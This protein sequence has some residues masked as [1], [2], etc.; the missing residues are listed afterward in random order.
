MSGHFYGL[1]DFDL[2]IG[3]HNNYHPSLGLFLTKYSFNTVGINERDIVSGFSLYPNPSSNCVNI[4]FENEEQSVN[5]QVL[6]IHGQQVFF[7]EYNS[8][9]H[10]QLEVNGFSS[11]I[12]MVNVAT[13]T[14]RKVLKFIKK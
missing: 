7:K 12:Y 2:G 14:G 6:N 5:L 8:T 4:D 13:E 3:I 11:G 1:V 10:I 9:D